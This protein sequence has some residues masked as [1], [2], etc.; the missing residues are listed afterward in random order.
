MLSSVIGSPDVGPE[1]VAIV[2]TVTGRVITG[3]ARGV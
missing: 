3:V 2:A 1:L